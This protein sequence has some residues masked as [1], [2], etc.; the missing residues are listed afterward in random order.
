MDNR[1]V[2]ALIA[3]ASIFV[4]KW[5]ADWGSSTS[6]AGDLPQAMEADVIRA[7]SLG[8]KMVLLLTG[9]SWCPACQMMDREM[10]GDP[11]WQAFTEGEVVFS[12][13]DFPG[14][15]GDPSPLQ[16]ELMKLPGVT[17]FPSVVVVDGEGEVLGVKTG[18]D[19]RGAPFYIEWIRSM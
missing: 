11:A 15:S 9:T 5:V 19:R 12:A 14:P 4:F 16:K 1:I 13:E 8:K 17:G 2:L 7:R 18:Y 3:G 6:L 10:L